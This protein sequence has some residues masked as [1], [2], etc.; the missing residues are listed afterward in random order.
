MFV[1]RLPHETK[2][3]LEKNQNLGILRAS[4][5]R[6]EIN[7]QVDRISTLFICMKAAK[8]SADA[9]PTK[10]GKRDSLTFTW[11]LNGV[12]RINERSRLSLSEVLRIRRNKFKSESRNLK[13]PK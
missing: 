9:Q 6:G 8:Q 7:C 12:T 1:T 4:K 5:D 10:A 11:F 2:E 3:Y 13:S